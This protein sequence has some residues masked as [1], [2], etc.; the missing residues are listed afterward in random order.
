MEKNNKLKILNI[1]GGSKQG[2]AEKFF[3]RLSFAIEKKKNINLQL[4]IRK[5][6]ERFSFLKKKIKSI[7]QINNFYFYNPFCHKEI[8]DVIDNFKPNIVLSWMNRAS[9]ILPKSKGWINIGRIGGY[10]KIKNYVNCDFIITNTNDLRD[11][12]I[13]SGWDPTKVECIPNFVNRNN[14]TIKKK[15]NSL[16]I[17]LC[18]AR[19]HRNKG[20]DVL[21]KAM[22]YLNDYILWIV[23]EGSERKF[24][25]LILEKHNLQEKVFF[26][27]WTNNIS[28]FMNSADLLV[29]PS[30]HEPFGNVVIDGWAHKIPV[31][32]SNTGGPGILIKNNVNGLKFKNEDFFDLIEKVKFLESKKSLLKKIVRNGYNEY[33][34]NFSE[35]LIINKYINFFEKI[36][37]Q[38]VE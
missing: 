38:C 26:Y 8:T 10:Y 34:S 15:S 17:I 33:E 22:T 6:Q 28:E 19:F 31:I 5:N 23:G 14:Q 2:G 37:K 4:I 27:E 12:V 29:C 32:V 20:I 25:D 9:K 7:H 13:E 11:F 18:L 16:K 21:L 30:R 3:E 35:D 1:L 24:Y 36:K